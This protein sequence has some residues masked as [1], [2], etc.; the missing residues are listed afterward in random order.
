[1]ARLNE[2]DSLQNTNGHELLAYYATKGRWQEAQ[3]VYDE[4]FRYASNNN[5]NNLGDIRSS[6]ATYGLLMEAYIRGDSVDEAIDIYY[7]LKDYMDL[8]PMA[9]QQKGLDFGVSLYTQLITALSDSTTTTPTSDDDTVSPHLGYTVDDGAQEIMNV[10]KDCSSELRMA[11]LL[12]QDMRQQGLQADASIYLA[13]LQR[14]GQEKDGYLVQ[15]VHQYLRMDDGIEMDDVMVYGLMD[16]Y[17]RV[18][19]EDAMVFELWENSAS[20]SDDLL[21]LVLDMCREKRYKQHAGRVW[22][23]L[24]REQKTA[25]SYRQMV[26]CLCEANEWQQA[27]Q[28]V[29][30]MHGQ[31]APGHSDMVD[32]LIDYGKEQ[33]IQPDQW[34]DLL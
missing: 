31:E 10:A 16:A 11:M 18:G 1:M 28:L 17:R 30:D 2:T 20:N 15:Q 27:K 29:M 33:G 8:H 23:Q 9:A 7:S 12:F 14:C 25:S 22:A 24:A 32:L 13:L 4:V 6:M 26:S 5:N 21:T 19:D 34:N 3:E